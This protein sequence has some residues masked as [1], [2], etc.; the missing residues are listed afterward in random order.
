MS[1]P[2][3]GDVIVNLEA[4]VDGL[5]YRLVELAQLLENLPPSGELS[6][7]LLSLFESGAMFVVENC[8]S[9][10]AKDKFVI[11][12]EPSE[13]FFVV[14]AALRAGNLDLELVKNLRHGRI[15]SLESLAASS[16]DGNGEGVKPS[17]CLSGDG[18]Q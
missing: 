18:A 6:Q 13:T 16:K 14:L 7:E 3:A 5:K 9:A 8:G 17:P 10:A 11:G 2:T 12:F 4:S 1:R 15:P